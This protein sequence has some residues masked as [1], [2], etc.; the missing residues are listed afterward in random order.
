M[1]F[2][3]ILSKLKI[4]GGTETI[5]SVFY[6]IGILG[7]FLPSH[8]ILVFI[9]CISYGIDLISQLATRKYY[10]CSNCFFVLIRGTCNVTTWL[11]NDVLMNNKLKIIDNVGRIMFFISLVHWGVSYPP[12]RYLFSFSELAMAL[13]LSSKRLERNITIF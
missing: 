1:T 4:I 7:N 5:I 13:I 9:Q 12:T 8:A 2:Q 11:V 3:C 10:S 6:V